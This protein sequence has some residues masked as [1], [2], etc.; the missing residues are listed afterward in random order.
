[1][2]IA[3]IL[4]QVPD[5]EARIVADPENPAAIVES[6]VKFI[7]NPYDEYAVEEALTLA[8]AHGGEVIG[9]CIGPARSETAVRTALAMGVSRAV[10]ISDAEAVKADVVTQARIIAAVLKTLD[11]SVVLC[12]KEF[13]DSQEDAMAAAVGHFSA[14]PHVL[15][16][17]K[18]TINPPAFHA[19]REIEGGSLEIEGTLP[20]VISC[21][22][23]LNEPRYPNLI[24]IRRAKNKE[25]KMLSLS[26]MNLQLDESKSHLLAFREP[27]ARSAG[28]IVS[29]EPQEMVA[30][31]VKWLSEEARIV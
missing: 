12:G 10:M 28:R 15:N 2:N 5:T 21:S 4:R 29:G 1:M 24:A 22:K 3:V 14:M 18:L 20:M 8:D 25:I 23:D 16:V 30:E 7:L 26:D 27:P 31:V 13:I 19:V 17:S 11:A 6:N 9:I